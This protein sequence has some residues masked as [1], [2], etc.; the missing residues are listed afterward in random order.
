M[1]VMPT[2]EYCDFKRRL[3]LWVCTIT[4]LKVF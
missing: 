1:A 3:W 4:S 2:H